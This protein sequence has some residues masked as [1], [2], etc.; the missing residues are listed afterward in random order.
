MLT[1]PNTYQERKK[2]FAPPKIEQP[3]PRIQYRVELKRCMRDDSELDL[4]ELVFD[5]PDLKNRNQ[6]DNL[7]VLLTGAWLR[8]AEEAKTKG[9]NQAFLFRVKHDTFIERLELQEFTDTNQCVKVAIN[10]PLERAQT[11]LSQ[12]HFISLNWKNYVQYS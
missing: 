5:V 11:L 7:A 10:E 3:K 12:C 2:G 8:L 9:V 1:F 6:A 4:G